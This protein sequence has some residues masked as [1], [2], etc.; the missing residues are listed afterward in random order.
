MHCPCCEPK[1]IQSFEGEP[2][3]IVTPP[4][5][6]PRVHTVLLWHDDLRMG[7]KHCDVMNSQSSCTGG[8]TSCA[9]T[10]HEDSMPDQS[11]NLDAWAH[12]VC[13]FCESRSLFLFFF[14][15]R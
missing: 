11:E 4:S 2:I 1:T 6:K 8:G 7:K 3:T 15:A 10:A 13:E 9:F 12:H 14:C 5:H